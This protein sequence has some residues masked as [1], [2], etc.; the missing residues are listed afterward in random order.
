MMTVTDAAKEQIEKS[1]VE[2]NTPDLPLRIAIKVQQ[3][4]SFHYM[5]GFD[6]NIDAGDF[7]VENTNVIVDQ[8]SQPLATGMTM[9]FVEIDG[10]MEFIFLNPNDPGYKAPTE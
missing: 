6:D 9:D 5:M 10:K 1:R 4:G 7:K 2:T 3:D 8:S